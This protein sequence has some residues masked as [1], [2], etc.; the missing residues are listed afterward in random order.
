ML[1]NMVNAEMNMFLRNEYVFEKINLKYFIT[2]KIA[3][4]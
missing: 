4:K 1:E 2:Q 3:L